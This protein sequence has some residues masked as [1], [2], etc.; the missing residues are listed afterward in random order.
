MST[1]ELFMETVMEDTGYSSPA[2]KLLAFFE[3]SRNRWKT[4]ALEREQRIRQLEK[5][6]AELKTSRHKWKQKAQ[7]P[8]DCPLA[9]GLAKPKKT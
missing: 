8:R 2:H 9:H 3:K 5:R 1:K 6:I 7:T 4:K